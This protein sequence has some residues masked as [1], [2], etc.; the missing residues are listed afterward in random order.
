M[1]DTNVANTFEWDGAVTVHCPPS[2][3]DVTTSLMGEWREYT[4]HMRP[5]IIHMN[6]MC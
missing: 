5:E 4:L 1:G 2:T 3:Q 6:S